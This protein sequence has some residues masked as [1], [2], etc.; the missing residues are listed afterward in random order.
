[1]AD[2]L[3]P[4]VETASVEGLGIKR[5]GA[6]LRLE[7]ARPEKRNALSF[8][9][10]QRLV[11]A[12]GQA[13]TDEGL[14]A[15][16]IEA[17]GEHFCTGADYL[18]RNRGPKD[19]DEERPRTGSIQ[20]RLPQ[21]AHRLI[22]LIAELQLP[23]VCAV[24]GWC[25]GIGL[26]L[27]LASDFC[28]ASDTARL[29]EPFAKRGFTPDSGGSWLLTRLVGVARAKQMLL[30]GREVSAEEAVQW[31]MIHAQVADSELDARALALARELADGPTVALG[32]M[33]RL[34]GQGVVG[35]LA[36]ALEHEA[37]ALELASRSP[38]FREGMKAFAEKRDPSFKGR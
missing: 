20:R 35:G 9:V 3:S 14:R 34:I 8:E 38:D 6:I 7:L 33:K 28:L 21:Q 30:L 18:A 31:G 1:M 19:K 15:V 13:A 5:D 22:P 29:W 12:F 23:V 16:L 25:S 27:A 10:Q 11:T 37:H 26:H 32:L 24:R 4:A 2:L 17:A 36:Q